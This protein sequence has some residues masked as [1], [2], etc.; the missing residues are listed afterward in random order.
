MYFAMTV[1]AVEG[2]CDFG[3]KDYDRMTAELRS[4]EVGNEYNVRLKSCRR[5]IAQ[6]R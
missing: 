5:V 6:L 1:F 2:E 4:E 3:L